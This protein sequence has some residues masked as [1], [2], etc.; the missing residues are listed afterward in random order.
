MFELAG[1]PPHS[2]AHVVWAH[3]PIFGWAIHVK[4]RCG[5]VMSK[6]VCPKCALEMSPTKLRGEE[7]WVR[8]SDNKILFAN[9][10]FDGGCPQCGPALQSKMG[11]HGSTQAKRLKKLFPEARFPLLRSQ[12]SDDEFRRLKAAREGKQFLTE[13]EL[14]RSR[15][16]IE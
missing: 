10:W 5:V 3:P 15:K 14:E 16:T 7:S 4:W 1:L 11:H 6:L 9:R 13:E 12:L 2:E 8:L